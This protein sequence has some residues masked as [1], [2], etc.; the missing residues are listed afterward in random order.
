MRGRREVEWL[1]I[2]PAYYENSTSKLR[3]TIL[4]RQQNASLGIV[5]Q[6]AKL[7]DESPI[8]LAMGP[9]CEALDILQDEALRLCLFDNTNKLVK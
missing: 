1:S 7:H 8:L 2:T 3:N 4:R 9:V 6:V 5:P